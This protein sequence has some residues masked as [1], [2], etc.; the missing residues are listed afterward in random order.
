MLTR[1]EL[2]LQLHVILGLLHLYRLEQTPDV[3]LCQEGTA[4]YSPDFIDASVEFKLSLK[5]SLRV[6]CWYLI[7]MDRD[8]VTCCLSDLGDK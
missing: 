3:V 1:I 8:C 7:P 2:Q 5:D 6:Y 4:Q